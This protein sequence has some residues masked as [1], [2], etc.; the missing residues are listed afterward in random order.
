MECYFL[1]QPSDRPS[2][3]VLVK[4][5]GPP[6]NV[7]PTVASI[8]KAVDPTVLPE[9][10]LMKSAFQQKMQGPQYS[11]L[12]VSLLAFVALLLACVGIVG[13]VASWVR[14]AHQGNRDCAWPWAPV[15]RTS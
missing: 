4:T 2:M 14:A 5:S 13:L 7:T 8:A 3:A 12:S 10:Q 1:A 11:A 6:E 15:P 9:I